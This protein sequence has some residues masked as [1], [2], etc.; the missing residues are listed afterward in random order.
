MGASWLPAT[1]SPRTMLLLSK[2]SSQLTVFAW[3]VHAQK[4]SALSRA[5]PREIA[6]LFSAYGTFRTSRVDRPP[7]DATLAGMAQEIAT[8]YA[9]KNL[10]RVVRRSAAGIRIKL[11]RYGKTQAVLIPEDDFKFLEKCERGR[12]GRRRSKRR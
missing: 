5:E 10:A 1:L 8:A 3:P 2:N 4:A 9:R 12:G 11:T 6:A 7:I